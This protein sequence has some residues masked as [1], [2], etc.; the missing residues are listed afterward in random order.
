MSPSLSL[1]DA[2]TGKL[3]MDWIVLTAVLLG[4]CASVLGLLGEDIALTRAGTISGPAACE[5]VEATACLPR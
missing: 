1:L 5:S 2:D 4:T 3:S